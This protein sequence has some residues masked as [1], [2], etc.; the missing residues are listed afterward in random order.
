MSS[1]AIVSEVPPARRLTGYRLDRLEVFNWG[2]FDG[3]VFTANPRGE[4][5]LL[6][7]ENGSGKST[8]VDA[9][10]TLLVK[11]QVRNYN[12]AAGAG[13][14]ER[15]EKSYIRGA[16]DR[17]VRDNGQ[18]QTEYHR[19]ERGSYSALLACFRHA[20]TDRA[21]TLCQV[22]YLD[23][24]NAVQK[25]FAFAD[26]SRTIA[27]DLSNVSSPD[28]LKRHLRDKGY[29]TTDSYT[30][31]FA[32]IKKVV[33]FRDKAMD[34][35]NQTV[36][37][38]D[39]QRLDEF[40]RRHMLE[41]KPW[42][43]RV[44]RLLTHFNEL[45]EAY[46]SLKIVREQDE[47]LRP[48]VIA[49]DRFDI[50]Q[51]ECNRCQ[52][53]LFATPL[54][55][56]DQTVRLLS[57][58][59][60]QWRSQI[61]DLR[62]EVTRLATLQQ[63]L[64]ER[65]ARL[66]VDI[67]TAGG[68]RVRE[69]PGLIDRE[70][71]I[72]IGK[73]KARATFESQIRHAGIDAPIASLEQFATLH[74]LIAQRRFEV[75]EQRDGLRQQGHSMRVEIASLE[76][77]H[78]D[79]RAELD[80]L[81][82]RKGNLPESLVGMRDMMCEQLKLAP[83][84]LPFA[85]ELVAVATDF[86]DWEASIEQVLY[87]FA[88][89]LLVPE[90]SYSR[91]SAHI[92]RT[93]MLDRKGSGQRLVYLRVGHRAAPERQRID[94]A[95]SLAGK[96]VYNESHPLY[97]WIKAEIIDRFDYVACDTIEQFQ[98]AAGPAMTRNRHLKTGNSR[99]EKD[100]RARP[101]DRRHF[102]LGWD[103]RAKRLSLSDA[104]QSLT[105]DIE[106][107][108][109]RASQLDR[110]VDSVTGV[111]QSLDSAEKVTRFEEIDDQLHRFHVSQLQLERQ[112]L[113]ESDDQIRELRAQVVRLVDEVAGH[114]DDRDDHLK[115]LHQFE[116]DLKNG[117]VT[118]EEN[119]KCIASAKATDRW[120]QAVECFG[121]I[122]QGLSSPLAIESLHSLPSR[123]EREAR[124][125]LEQLQKRLSPMRDDLTKAMTRFLK[126]FPDEQDDLDANEK[127][128]PSF[129]ALHERIVKDDLPRHEDRFRSRLQTKVLHEIGLLNGNL[130]SDCDEIRDKIAQLNSALTKLDWNPGTHMRLELADNKDREIQDFRMELRHCLSSSFEGTTE[131][132]ES[133]YRRVEVL[134]A[135]LGDEAAVRWREKVVDVRNWF[136]FA[137]QEIVRGS[138]EKRS[139]YDGGSGQSGGEKG[140]LAFLV[141]VA[142]IAY[143]YDLDPDATSSDKFHFVMVDEMFSR[144]DDAHAR[145]ALELFDRFGLQL[146]IVAPLDAKVRVAQ[147]YVGAYLHVVKDAKT[148]KSELISVTAQQLDE[149]MV[150]P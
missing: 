134:V 24:E 65:I 41:T 124:E 60:L 3:S 15:N 143:Q 5:M 81:Q 123:G 74:K 96:L 45:R 103:N 19:S 100:D 140:K 33:G 141:L 137:A 23:S 51:A 106:Q 71:Q 148:N 32:W 1:E 115:Q 67:E 14:H 73:T 6:V 13:R 122:A 59:R 2:T 91:V 101:D 36:A 108:K 37:V 30:A 135:K 126:K 34:I 138:G 57:P 125:R 11:P 16:H 113:E 130:E 97:R 42:K 142:A 149:A 27:G 58:L 85:A 139:F 95:R 120:E 131:A 128:L 87:G 61:A 133:I 46:R 75:T 53:M 52:Q 84:E 107:L 112:K 55:F 50:L 102:V 56:A 25:I 17:T 49:G 12:V 20:A 48:I 79:D 22:L 94:G 70:E 80:A 105:R 64:Q 54:F 28:S 78:A 98:S 43:Q 35:L 44:D 47:L 93:R 118:I 21:F 144:S 39:V 90:S 117:E 150:S 121:A 99:H 8:L 38:K 109:A 127:S 88:R 146:L 76:K 119:E 92:D 86:G 4:T 147:P 40:I 111:L 77:Q 69:L 145:A 104:I 68:Q 31:Y 83:S 114:G 63:S 62:E 82:R 116:I 129:R 66:K 72:A 110:D 26:S 89:S 136:G 9:L 18:A 29:R 7:G 10:L 132:N